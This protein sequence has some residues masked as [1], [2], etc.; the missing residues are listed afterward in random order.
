MVSYSI[1]YLRKYRSHWS[2]KFS[3]NNIQLV[4]SRIIFEKE[5]MTASVSTALTKVCQEVDLAV[6]LMPEAAFLVLG[7]LVLAVALFS[8]G[9]GIE[10]LGLV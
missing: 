2:Q 7:C 5:W 10:V 9:H 3:H 6:L 8:L 1:K 4:P